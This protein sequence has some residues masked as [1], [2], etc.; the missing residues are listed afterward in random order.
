MCDSRSVMQ[1]VNKVRQGAL[2]CAAGSQ[3][4]RQ[5]VLRIRALIR[6]SSVSCSSSV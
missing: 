3:S 4:E 2:L 1:S 6:A 5:T